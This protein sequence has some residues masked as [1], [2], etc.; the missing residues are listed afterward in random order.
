MATRHGSFEDRG[1]AVF[2]VTTATLVLATT[3]VAMRMVCRKFIVRN[4]SWDDW[5]IMLAWVIAF[6]LSFTI[7]YGTR[8]GLGRHDRDIVNDDWPALQRCQYV[9]SVLYNPALMAT[10]TSILVFYLRLAKNTQK[11]LRFA[12]W[13]TLGVVNVAGT[14][15]T[16]MNIFQ[17]KPI[18][19]A[20]NPWD[21]TSRCIPLLTE[22][23]C[24]APVNIVTDLAILA[25]PIPVLTGMSLPPRQKTILVLTFGLGI[26]VTIVDVVRIYYLQQAISAVPT[27]LSKDPNSRFGGQEE[28]SFNASFSLMWSAVEV[29]I[30]MTCACIPT[31]KPLIIKIL[32]AMIID[33]D[34]SGF[35]REKE[36]AIGGGGA[37]G[38]LD[39]SSTMQSTRRDS[40]RSVSIQMPRASYLSH[41]QTHRGSRASNTL[42]PYPE[43]E[44]TTSLEVPPNLDRERSDTLATLTGTSTVQSR[45]ESAIYFGFV[46]MKKPKSM[47]RCSVSES[48]KYCTAVTVLF[49][50][51]GVSYG[52]LNT[53]NNAVAFVSR[54]SY[55]QTLGLTSAYFGGGYF[56][57]PLLVGEWILRR[58]EHH[59]TRRRKHNSRDRE[60]IGGFK[61]TFIVGLCFYGVGT[62]IFWPSAVTNS[63]GGFMLSNFVVGFGLSILETGANAFL[64]LC[65]P[66]R[67]ADARLMLA[68]GVQAVGSVLSGLLAQRVFFK[69]LRPSQG[70]VMTSMI[71]INVQWSYLAIT[72]SCVIL[73]LFFYYM[74]LPEVG[75]LELDAASRVLPADPR[76]RSVGGIQVRTWA[77][78]LAVLAQWTYMGAQECTSIFWRQLILSLVPSVGGAALNGPH[79]FM[80]SL[81][82]PGELAISVPDYLLIAQTAFALSRFAVSYLIYLSLSNPRIPRPR[83]ILGICVTLS[84]VF[85]LLTV[86]I[87]PSNPNL[88]AIPVVLLYTT[89]GPCWPL[90]FSLGLRGQGRRTKRA[91]AF[92]TMGGSGPAFFPFI[93]YGIVQSGGTIQLAFIVIAVL[94]FITCVYPAYLALSKDAGK[95]VD[96]VLGG[97]AEGGAGEGTG[98][99]SA[100]TGGEGDREGEET[101]EDILRRRRKSSAA[102]GRVGVGERFKGYFGGAG[103]PGEGSTARD[104][105]LTESQEKAT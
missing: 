93:M 83:T 54:M 48:W 101:V 17:C 66:Q 31:L 90:I 42:Q 10:K 52:L 40:R 36:R 30:G 20:W 78:A 75:D 84:A 19:A 55:P 32:P 72:L 53:L 65:G 46:N 8:M 59:R 67:Y 97:E 60:G 22:F 12:S 51:W 44:A 68:Q 61:V 74:P 1:P 28:F 56:F 13:A 3:F 86:V 69:G 4:I 85:A 37:N 81:D 82:K 79:D 64:I 41:P 63:F 50:L 34:G 98:S 25:L 95:M 15:L 57:G 87:R 73:A 89:E 24:S 105:S 21:K 35:A 6:G 26:F 33:P 16:F 77:L 23:I 103:E 43:L 9:F 58:D 7:N 49:L 2:A 96:P 11:V 62:I 18:D 5:I 39:V 29:N 102:L 88:A 76:R 45:Q 99:A 92:I 14:V 47:L 70:G 100:S 104:T 94:Q 38:N 91:A 80:S 71:F 27:S